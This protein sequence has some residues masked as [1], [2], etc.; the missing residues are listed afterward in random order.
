MIYVIYHPMKHGANGYDY[1]YQ[2][3]SRQVH[4]RTTP[5]IQKNYQGIHE[6]QTRTRC[7]ERVVWWER[8]GGTISYPDKQRAELVRF[9][10]QLVSPNRGHSLASREGNRQFGMVSHPV[11][12][13]MPAIGPFRSGGDVYFAA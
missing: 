2:H 6:R 1:S 3:I 11:S 12:E 8:K 10:G 4:D 9:G 7:S 5:V 13:A